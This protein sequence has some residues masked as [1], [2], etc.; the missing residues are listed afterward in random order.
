M[1]PANTRT[2]NLQIMRL[3]FLKLTILL[4]LFFA[5]AMQQAWACSN[6]STSC[7]K[8]VGDKTCCAK[9]SH[10]KEAGN[11]EQQDPTCQDKKGCDDHKCPCS[12]VNCGASGGLLVEPLTA[13]P[14]LAKVSE[15][16]LRQVFYFNQH[17]PE[18]VYLPIWQPPQLGV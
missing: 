18:A 15:G 2:F 6:G 16:E 3:R 1:K 17:M 4:L 11:G 14:T 12:T 9:S 8:S 7:E 5:G 10:E 13:F